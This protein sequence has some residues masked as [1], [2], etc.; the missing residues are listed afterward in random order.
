MA[1]VVL[2]HNSSGVML[3]TIAIINNK[4]GVG[5]TTTAVNVAAGLARRGR[6]VLLVDLDSQGSA[7]LSLGVDRDELSP[8]TADVLYNK[9][10]IQ[11]AIRSTDVDQFH[12]LTGHI[13][14][15][16]AD[17]VLKQKERGQYRLDRVLSHVRDDYHVI[18]IDCAPST[19]LLS[20]AALVAAD[21]F[22]V[23]VTPYYLSLEGV[24]S[25]GG[26]VQRVR[27]GLGQAAPLLGVLVTKVDPEIEAAQDFTKMRN[28]YGKKVFNTEIRRDAN[29]IEAPSHNQDIF[30]YAPDSKGA[31]DYRQL[32][33]ELE[34]RL[35]HYDSLFGSV[36]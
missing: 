20:I 16:N 6:R 4:G 28:H 19:T 35:E 29:L 3:K 7:S 15:A 9:A 36:A 14:L 2:G 11:E 30:R 13:D 22:I 27:D 32:V 31:E 24:V 25:L 10:D 8:S 12:L 34:K 23:P 33:D 17:V 1:G 18:L 21:G 26:V 5:K